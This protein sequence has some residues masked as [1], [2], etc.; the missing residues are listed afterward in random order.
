MA[1]KTGSAA[2]IAR[3]LKVSKL[4][5]RVFEFALADAGSLRARI[6]RSGI[7]VGLS[8]SLGSILNFVRSIV[9]ARLLTP[10]MFGLM[11]IA[12][13]AIRTIET[14]TR[15]GIA[16]ALIA[17][18][19]AFDEAAATA[20]TLLVARGLLLAVLLAG[21]APLVARFYE[22]EQ[23]TL[24]LQVLALVFVIGGLNNIETIAR[25]K[26]IDFRSLTY[27]ALA[28]NFLGTVAAIA[29]AFWLRNVWALVI[30]Q[31]ATVSFNAILSYRF[32]AGR[33]R[34]TLDRAMAGELVTYGKFITGSSIMM[35]V[36]AEIDTAVLGKL[37]GLEMV[38]LYVFAFTLANLATAQ[39][40]KSV[41]SVMMPAYSK[42][43]GD[44]L[45]LRRAFLRSL[46]FVMYLVMPICAGLML[47]AEPLIVFIYGNRWAP[48]AEALRILSLYGLFRSLASFSG[49]LFEGIGKPRNAFYIG[50]FR[51]AVVATLIVPMILWLGLV[52]AAIAAT[53]GVVAEYLFG[54]IFI[55]KHVGLTLGAIA[56][57]LSRP[58]WTTLLMSAAVLVPVRLMSIDPESKL[59]VGA[60][61]GILVYGTLNA[62]AL[63][64]LRT[65]GFS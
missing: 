3:L 23:L 27:L 45:A 18:K 50:A 31:I 44:T 4:I 1:D 14:F 40:S 36:A 9:L 28:S 5:N 41:S 11:G 17:S 43:Q 55:R 56:S 52:G 10:E 65:R 53:C 60:L 29:A 16:P 8:A 26:E 21:V 7:W 34:F 54:L 13:I 39:I 58:F 59:W 63:A 12:G 33:F 48:A 37:V 38:G 25:Q 15:P 22:N 6:F 49:Y 61:V 57:E 32:V 62:R 2:V 20:F 35:F 24:I 46:S 64:D 19:R 51:L 47:V 30:G 42:L